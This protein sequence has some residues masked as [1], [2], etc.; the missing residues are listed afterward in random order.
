MIDLKETKEKCYG[1]TACV[2]ICPSG[3]LEM[4]A[5]EFGFLYPKVTGH[6]INCGRCEKVCPIDKEL[7]FHSCG[8]SCYAAVS[9]T[10]MAESTSGGVGTVLSTKMLEK[11]GIVYGAGF[12]NGQVQYIRAASPEKV[13]KLQGSKYVQANLKRTFVHIAADLEEA[14]KPVLFIGTP[15]A[16]AALERFLEGKNTEKLVTVSF[17]CGGVPSPQFL[18]DEIHRLI[19][20]IP[21]PV[22]RFRRGSEYIF[23]CRTESG[24]VLKKVRRNRSAYLVGYDNRLTL[25]SCCYNCGFSQ[26][27]RVG[28]ITIGDFWGLKKSALLSGGKGG[29]SSVSLVIPTTEKGAA[30]FDSCKDSLDIETRP[31]EEALQKNARLSQPA[32]KATAN[33]HCFRD[34]YLELGFRKAIYAS[35]SY[36]DLLREH[37]RY[38][39]FLVPVHR[40]MAMIKAR[41]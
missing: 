13:K 11:K 4:A 22:V 26:K 38:S 7:P 14:E 25:R 37:Y 31:V 20:D 1:C 27:N 3:C 36:R 32:P 41:L 9:K 35:L 28:D 5:D 21:D 16:V 2:N 12:E 34:K 29:V 30:F 23:E 17:P 19:G 40:M 24:P 8:S 15:C 6:C 39:K 10:S 18:K 33:C